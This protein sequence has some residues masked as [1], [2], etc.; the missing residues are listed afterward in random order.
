M[1]H[2]DPPSARL[3]VLAFLALF[4]MAAGATPA[5]A[6]T[7]LVNRVYDAADT[8]LADGVCDV[9]PSAGSQ[10]T[11]RA[12]TQEARISLEGDT[13][14]LPYGTITLTLGAPD[15]DLSA[16]G[17]LDLWGDI[18][19]TGQL[20][21]ARTV[22]RGEENWEDRIFETRGPGGDTILLQR[23]VI[24]GG[25]TA[26]GG[27]LRLIDDDV[28][29][30]D[31]EVRDNHGEDGGGIY[32]DS[33]RLELVATSV[34]SNSAS[35]NGGGIFAWS[36]AEVVLERSLVAQNAS[37]SDGGGIYSL[38]DVQVRNSTVSS[39]LTYG[40]GGGL[41]IWA[42]TLD[43]HNASIVGNGANL[44]GEGTDL[45]GGIH[46]S[47][48]TG[49]WKSTVVANNL[50]L[51]FPSK[52]DCSIGPSA[53]VQ[54]DHLFLEVPCEGYEAGTGN[55][56]GLDPGL[57]P[58]AEGGGPTRGHLPG[59]GSPLID[60]GS[61][62]APGGGGAA[63]ETV[64]QRGAPRPEDGDGSGGAR[65]DI[66]AMEAGAELFSDGFESGGTALWS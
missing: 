2:F 36:D 60:S 59:A 3:A 18:V 64:D 9:S 21:G 6:S 54:T 46:M 32:L 16:S 11:L 55:Q 52:A 26:Q 31:C 10:C 40:A 43:L 13:I 51:G 5:N 47:T 63:C 57:G 62:L 22:I 44:D 28:T 49:S 45:G 20:S 27:G 61:P 35:S 30:I 66:G 4:E 14:V 24:E 12:A 39:N 42:G 33:G 48:G 8:N 65:C 17:D 19:I 34:R 23:V 53:T 50:T 58:L 25:E 15:E 37:N 38:A 1:N 7:F 56:T 29:L 41:Y